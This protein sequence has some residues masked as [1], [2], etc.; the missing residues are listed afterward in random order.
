MDYCGGGAKRYV[1]PPSQVIGGPGPPAPPPPPSSYAYELKWIFLS[2]SVL[3]TLVLSD[4]TAREDDYGSA[5]FALS[6]RT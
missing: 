1:G 5:Y 3:G 4:K 6:F 2:T